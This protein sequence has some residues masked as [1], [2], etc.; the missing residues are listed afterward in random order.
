MIINKIN[1]SIYIVDNELSEINDVYIP[2]IYEPLNCLAVVLNDSSQSITGYITNIGYL[3]KFIQ[4]VIL[5]DFDTWSTIK[6]NFPVV[7]LINHKE[8]K[9]FPVKKVV[10]SDLLLA[11]LEYNELGNFKKNYNLIIDSKNSIGI[12][13]DKECTKKEID[14]IFSEIQINKE[15]WK[16]YL[17]YPE[18]LYDLSINKLEFIKNKIKSCNENDKQIKILIKQIQKRKQKEKD[19]HF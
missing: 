10:P 7:K 5:Q 9:E 16:T 6:S 15:F 3:Y 2:E 8:N 11:C 12:C 13:I 18:K 19:M 17:K 1:M 4:P 14:H